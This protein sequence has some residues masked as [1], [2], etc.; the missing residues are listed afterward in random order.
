M[1]ICHQCHCKYEGPGNKFC[2]PA[3][4]QAAR[5]EYM[6]TYNAYYAAWIRPSTPKAPKPPRLYEDRQCKRP[7][8]G[9]TFTPHDP[10]QLYCC[11]RCSQQMHVPSNE[12][13][14][15]AILRRILKKHGMAS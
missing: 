12:T 11:R 1:R 8:C 14:R 10:K 5:A 7:D 4:R 13:N 15:A 2:S 3:C 6:R 9:A